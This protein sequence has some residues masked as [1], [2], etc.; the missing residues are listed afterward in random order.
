MLTS[1]S[2]KA[3]FQLY[4][5]RCMLTIPFVDR[6]GFVVEHPRNPEGYLSNLR[7]YLG[8]GYDTDSL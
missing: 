3:Y 5:V 7:I 8:G 1:L 4:Y 6:Q 2:R